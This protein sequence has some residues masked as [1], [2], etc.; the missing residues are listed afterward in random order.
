[1][2][3]WSIDENIFD[4][5]DKAIDYIAENVDET[6][7]FDDEIDDAGDVV[8]CGITF[9]RSHILKECDP[10]AYHCYY[11]DFMD[12]EREY[13]QTILDDMQDGDTEEYYGLFI[14]CKEI[15]DDDEI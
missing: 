3:F 14:D 1:M 6:D 13:I 11:L 5:V 10:T 8:I 15:E 4:D 7:R 12:A 9:N 2:K